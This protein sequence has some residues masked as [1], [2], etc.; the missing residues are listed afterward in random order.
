M[1]NNGNCFLCVQNSS[2]WCYTWNGN[3]QI[4]HYGIRLY[5]IKCGKLNVTLT[6]KN[7]ENSNNVTMQNIFMNVTPST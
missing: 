2:D 3:C 6:F 1:T 7:K 5:D 4:Y